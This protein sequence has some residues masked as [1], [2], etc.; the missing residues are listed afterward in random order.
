MLNGLT[1]R[2]LKSALMAGAAV[3]TI[4][5]L[6]PAFAQD[7]DVEKVT[8]TG[9]RIPQKGLTSVSPVVTIDSKE[10]LRQGTTSAE[11][12]LNSMPQVLAN[13]T[14]EQSNG[15]SGTASIDLR[16]LG[17]QRTL[18]LI[19]GRRMNPAS[20]NSPYADLNNIPVALL[21]RVEILS[22]GASAVY[23]ADAVAG[24]V[25]FIMRK[26]FEGVL[27]TAQYGVSMH[28]NDDTYLRGVV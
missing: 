4:G 26:D 13:Q 23:G 15:A 14:P 5:S 20:V 2:T 12:L 18:V 8:V 19:N 10:S 25:N 24:V 7:K 27:V 21:E 22:G 1:N 28:E 9:T 11:Q 3:A 16:G 6:A 17:P